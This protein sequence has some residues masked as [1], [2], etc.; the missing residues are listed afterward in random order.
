MKHP[1]MNF[2]LKSSYREKCNLGHNR[3]MC[4]CYSKKSFFLLE[5]LILI[6]LEAKMAD[7]VFVQ[8]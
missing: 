5:N 4:I 1:I 6:K 2:S 8:K 3:E 7:T